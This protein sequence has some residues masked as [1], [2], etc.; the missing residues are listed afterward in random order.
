MDGVETLETFVFYDQSFSNLTIETE[1]SH[2]GPLMPGNFINGNP[3]VKL[4]AREAIRCK[5]LQD[6]KVMASAVPSNMA[7]VVPAAGQLWPR[8]DG[9]WSGPFIQGDLGGSSKYSMTEEGLSIRTSMPAG[10]CPC[11]D[12]GSCSDSNVGTEVLIHWDTVIGTE[13]FMATAVAMSSNKPVCFKVF[14]TFVQKGYGFGRSLKPVYGGMLSALGS[15]E[16][17]FTPPNISPLTAQWLG[18]PTAAVPQNTNFPSPVAFDLII[19]DWKPLNDTN[20]SSS[21]YLVA[22]L[23]ILSI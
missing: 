9:N 6:W 14:F 4:T 10:Q 20:S 8:N 21:Q 17:C 3:V 13:G 5:S 18:T 2:N 12:T 16:I 19:N 15:N 23:A 11:L 7:L 22:A 1:P